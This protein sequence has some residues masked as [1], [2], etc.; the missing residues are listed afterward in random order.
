MYEYPTVT[1]R[2]RRTYNDPILNCVNGEKH[3][4]ILIERTT[5]RTAV[6]APPGATPTTE[7]QGSL[8]F[9]SA[10]VCVR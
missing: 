10:L 6:T 4:P 7:S 3:I 1:Q 2:K 8:T 5:G 9:M